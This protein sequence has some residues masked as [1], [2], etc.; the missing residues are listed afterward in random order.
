[1][2]PLGQTLLRFPGKTKEWLGNGVR[3]WWEEVAPPKKAIYKRETKQ[4]ISDGIEEYN[5]PIDLSTEGDE[6]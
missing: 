6:V 1:M 5:D 2:K 3:M 4:L